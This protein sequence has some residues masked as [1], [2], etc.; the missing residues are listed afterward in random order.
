MA[1]MMTM[2]L[3]FISLPKQAKRVQKYQVCRVV[4]STEY[5]VIIAIHDAIP[6][7]AK[8]R[9]GSEELLSN[10]SC[11]AAIMIGSVETNNGCRSRLVE[12]YSLH[13]IN[14]LFYRDRVGAVGLKLEW[15]GSKKGVK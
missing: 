5:A 12:R 3:R 14:R 6:C 9:H 4:D 11:L 1:T 8:K 15:G 2:R 13:P 7:L 10:T